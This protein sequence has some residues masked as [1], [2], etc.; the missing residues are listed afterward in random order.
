MS[1]LEVRNLKTYFYLDRNEYPA[2]DDISFT[3]DEGKTIAIIGESGSGKSVT[4]L[5]IMGLVDFP[6]KIIGGEV[7][8][9]GEDLLKKGEREMQKIRGNEIAMIYQD[10]MST[11]N[12]MIKVGKQ[13]EEALIIHKKATKKDSKKIVVELMKAVGIPDGEERY[14]H[15]PEQFSGG[16]RQRLMIAMAIACNPK[17]LIADEPT[18]ALDVTIQAEILDLLRNLR[19]EY[20][21]SIILNT[22]DL[23]VVAEM[24]DEVVVMYCGKIMEIAPNKELFKNPLNPYTQKLMEC[25]PRIDDRKKRLDTIE[26]YVPHL[27]ELPKGCRF[28]DRCHK[29]FDRCKDELPELKEISKE[30]WSR[31]WLHEVE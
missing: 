26:G 4:S 14:N 1:L 9:R 23:G 16:M 10:P 6:G 19:N 5:S 29:A 20:N 22:H 8:Y 3:L 15:L 11:L 31:C 7:Y 18:T 12:P 13:I 28:S 21:M 2:V 24:A 25:I 30:H 27:T 17:I